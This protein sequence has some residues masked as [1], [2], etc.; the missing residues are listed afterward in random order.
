MLYSDLIMQESEYTYSVNIQF[1]IE[2]DTMFARFIPNETTIELLKEYFVDIIKPQ[3]DR[4][5]RILYGSYGTGKSHFLTV[6]S[7]LL[8]KIHTDGVAYNTFLSRI[9]NFDPQLAN[10]IKNFTNS[11]KP[12]LIV[13]I[14]FD[15]DDFEQCIFFS[16][17]K[18]LEEK[19]IH[20]NF[21]SSF[22]YA[23]ELIAQWKGHEESA[24]KLEEACKKNNT[25]I[26][27]L[28]KL[29]NCFEPKAQK[30]FKKVFSYMT[31]GVEYLYESSNITE[32]L[33]QVNEAI[34]NGYAGIV[35]IFD[36]F[37]RY[38]EDNIKK[39]KVKAVQGLAEYCDHGDY[40]NH[41]ILV[42]HKEISQYTNEYS[43]TIVNE[44]KKVEG[45]FKATSINDKQDQCLSLIKNIIVKNDVLWG[46]FKKQFA[47]ELD[48]LYL[49]AIDFRGFLINTDNNQNP[50]EACFP[51]HPIALYTLDKLSKKVAQNERTFFTYLASKDEYS[52]NK[53]LEHTK[54]NEFHFVGVDEIY[55]YFEPNIKSMQ[56]DI[57][58][59]WYHK[60]QSA[61]YKCHRSISE[62]TPD[63]R[64]LKT[65]TIIGIVNDSSALFANRKTILTVID[66]DDDV[67]EK[68]LQILCEKK[69]IKYSGLYDRYEFFDS[70]IFDLDKMIEDEVEN[71]N[72]DMICKTL[73][74]TFVDFVLYPN[75]YNEDYKIKRVFIP[76][77]TTLN[78]MVKKTFIKQAPEFYDGILALVLGNKEV[79]PTA[80]AESTAGLP[81][82]IAVIDCDCRKLIYEVKKYMAILYL[83][84]QK[85]KYMEKDPAIENEIDYYKMEQKEIISNLVY[86]W[87]ILSKET[88]FVA[89]GGHLCKECTSFEQLTIEASKIMAA[90]FPYTMIVNNELLNK[91]VLSGSMNA[92][93]KIAIRAILKNENVDD[94]YGLSE[95]SP[96]YICVRSVLAKT[97]LYPD[98]RIHR[99][100]LLPNGSNSTQYLIKIF[101]EHIKAYSNSPTVFVNLYNTLR[102]PPLGLRKGYLPLLLAY[103]LQKYRMRLIISSHDV[104]Q[105]ITAELF[106]EMITRPNDYKI[107]I[108]DWTDEQKQ[109]I[110]ALEKL[111]A[112]YINLNTQNKN[113]LKALYDAM[114]MHYK[115][116]SKFARTS[117]KYASNMTK[118]YRKLIEQ[119]Y[120][121]YSRFFFESLKNLS[122]DYVSTYEVIKVVKNELEH[123]PDNLVKDLVEDIHSVF[124]PVSEKENLCALLQRFYQNEWNE[125]K[126]KSFDY[127]TNSWLNMIGKL[128]GKEND[129][130]IITHLAK[131]ITG[132]DPLYWNDSHREEFIFR[133]KAIKKNFDSYVVSDSLSKGEMKMTL[134]YADGT[135]KAAIFSTSKLSAISKT[136]KNKI[137]ATLNN[138][139]LSISYDDKV[140]VLLSLFDDLLNDK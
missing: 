20:I 124:V 110:Y 22:T 49:E 105:E 139:G 72:D 75:R 17:R 55:D 66:E 88:T 5:S 31:F 121:N 4:H 37:G 125:K 54:L 42:S 98:K 115:S 23:Q 9:N 41:I 138:F 34:K 39:I 18:V 45:R 116:I 25:S 112:G 95:L 24:L 123:M 134:K 81:R 56:S 102:L 97:G 29:L 104:E 7:L 133:I 70:S 19:N 33:D 12:Y 59:E 109:Y 117:N 99:V 107:F 77:F 100:N 47:S 111:Y 62:N 58:Y 87:R 82:V 36:E 60:L 50:F 67:L 48:K 89:T 103:G 78:D 119:S 83:E 85:T 63:I 80:V 65:L 68:E 13:P 38:L 131:M 113:R 35:F 96:E 15:F 122:G 136:M 130:E 91:N 21:K 76:I 51:L 6:L 101:Q 120:T 46:E 53:F 94:Y 43:S 27:K 71:I 92:A 114:S 86:E 11:G 52:L 127:Y 118:A 1:D 93:K 132:F 26:E 57:S 30:L 108:A 64:I 69:V 3:S 44:W 126:C 40:D 129:N 10:D 84:S 32:S 74:S 79:I 61:L 73:N 106:D 28:E 16:L 135:E 2:S 14:V 128:S 8:G 140:Q 90:S 137:N